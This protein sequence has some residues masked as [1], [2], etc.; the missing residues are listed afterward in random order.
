MDNFT[1]S[2][3]GWSLGQAGLKVKTRKGLAALILGANMPDLDVFFGHSCWLPLA[4]HR[5]FTHSLVGGLIVMPPILA[6][7]LWL[8]DRWQVRRSAEF[9]SGLALHWGWLLALS[10]IGVLTHPFLDLLTSYAIQLL[11]PFSNRWFHEESLFIIDVWLWAILSLGIWL[12]RRRERAGRGWRKP[13]WFALAISLAY[14]AAN[15]GMTYRAKADLR[16]NLAPQV[17]ETA[18]AEFEPVKFWER[19]LAYRIELHGRRFVGMASWNPWNGLAIGGAPTPDNMDDPIVRRAMFATPDLA[20]FMR[21][22]VMPMATV[23]RG[24]CDARVSFTDARFSR[25]RTPWRKGGDPFRNEVTIP[26]TDP[27]CLPIRSNDP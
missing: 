12:S 16:E 20:R 26:L 22:S 8:L 18:F 7:L 24:R 6:G 9:K 3:V 2:L 11:S 4:T 19:G 15:W 5:G 25:F 27:G 14:I 23:R 10:Y 13:V 21:W 17:V 1:H